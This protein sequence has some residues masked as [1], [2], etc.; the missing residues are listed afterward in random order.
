MAM[1]CIHAHRDIY[2]HLSTTTP[3]SPFHS[4]K[5]SHSFPAIHSYDPTTVYISNDPAT[6]FY[7]TLNVPQ[8]WGFL[9]FCAI[10]TLPVAI[11]GLIASARFADHTVIGYV[12]LGVEA[13]TVLAWFAGWVAVA[14]SAGSG[15]CPAGSDYC[16]AL[17]AAAAFGALE[18]LLFVVTVTL[19][20]LIHI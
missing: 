18:W 2:P 19:L 14:A 10:L 3:I 5:D 6:P 16:G 1:V 9:L 20:S 13:F 8:S 7:A 11:L 17:R 12:R 4:T 15:T